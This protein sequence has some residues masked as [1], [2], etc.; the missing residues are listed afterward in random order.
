[1]IKD[2][3]FIAA[4]G[5]SISSL[6]IYILA[7]LIRISGD[8]RYESMIKKGIKNETLI[9]DDIY[10]LAEHWRIKRENITTRLNFIFNNLMNSPRTDDKQLA[11]LR[12]IMTWHKKQNPYSDLPE[13]IALHLQSISRTCSDAEVEIHRLV[14][15]LSE[16]SMSKQKASKR[17]RLISRASLFTGIMGVVLALIQ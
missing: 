2:I 9:N 16:Y 5:F 15:S 6:I 17:E 4:I 3:L 8:S 14:L 10:T 1:M 13:N 12:D 7:N 11:R